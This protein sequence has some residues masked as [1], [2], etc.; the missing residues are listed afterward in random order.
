MIRRHFLGLSGTALAHTF[1]NV[2]DHGAAGDGERLDTAAIQ[3]AIDACARSGGGAVY[4][5]PGAYVSGTI[6]LKSGVTLHLSPASRLLGSRNLN[7]YPEKVPAIRSYTDNYTRRSLIYAEDAERIAIEGGGVIDGQ[8]TAF[9]GPY[10]VRPYLVRMI[11]CRGIAVRDVTFRDSPMWVQHYLACEDLEIRGVTVRSQTNR[12]NDGIDIDS[13]RRVRIS[14][15]DV[16]SEDDALVFKSTTEK[17]CSDIVVTNCILSSLCNGIKFGT[18]SNGGFRNVTVT[19]CSIYDTHL[20]GIAVECVDGGVLDRVI[21][22]NIVMNAVQCPIFVRLNDRARPFKAGMERPP[23]GR[24]R[25]VSISN[26]VATGANKIGCSISGIADRPVE[27]IA[28]SNISISF[29]GGG[30]RADARRVIAEERDKY[31]EYKMM[32]ILPAYGFY[33]RHVRGLTLRDIRVTSDLPDLRY[34]LACEDVTG[35]DVS[36]LQAAAHPEG[37]ALMRFLDVRDA[38]VRGCRAPAGAPAFLHVGGQSGGITL[39]ANDLTGAK[40]PIEFDAGVPRAAV[41]NLS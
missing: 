35:L 36:G 4:F 38:L 33:C 32:G 23:V 8:G 26:I 37:E 7:D 13:C 27:N 10:L 11:N 12:N 39:A 28:L 40:T 1:T 5:P 21:A 19:N 2:R 6:V 20:A 3:A 15:C 22:S 30:T 34:A 17:P 31:P 14:D 29:A 9:R 24:L 41:R 18:E 16:N 25:N